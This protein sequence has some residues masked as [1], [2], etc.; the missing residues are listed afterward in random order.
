MTEARLACE[1]IQKEDVP[2]ARAKMDAVGKH[3]CLRVYK[4]KCMNHKQLSGG[5][6]ALKTPR[7]STEEWN[8]KSWRV[9]PPPACRRI[10]IRFWKGVPNILGTHHN[11]RKRKPPSPEGVPTFARTALFSRKKKKLAQMGFPQTMHTPFSRKRSPE[12]DQPNLQNNDLEFIITRKYVEPTC[13]KNC[14]GEMG[15]DA[16]ANVFDY[17]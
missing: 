15:C 4:Y 8:A 9:N 13:P 6:R 14:H 1:Q 10:R 16:A 2:E 17:L 12:R 3:T 11:E 5:S 7:Q